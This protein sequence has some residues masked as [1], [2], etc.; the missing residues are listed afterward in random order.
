MAQ[1]PGTQPTKK[2]HRTMKLFLVVVTTWDDEVP[3]HK[4]K[5]GVRLAP[6]GGSRVPG[7]HFD[8]YAGGDAFEDNT[9][10]HLRFLYKVLA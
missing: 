7:G 9:K 4:A 8:L 5:Q 2:V 1:I 3:L 10:R 6:L